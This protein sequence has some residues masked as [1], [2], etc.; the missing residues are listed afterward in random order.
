MMRLIGCLVDGGICFG[1]CVFLF[2]SIIFRGVIG[3]GLLLLFWGGF[4][5]FLGGGFKRKRGTLF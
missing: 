1:M 5:F 4:F 2:V 3:L